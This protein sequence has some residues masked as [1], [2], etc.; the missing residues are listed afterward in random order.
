MAGPLC[1]PPFFFK[2]MTDLMKCAVVLLV[3]TMSTPVLGQEAPSAEGESI[4]TITTDDSSYKEIIHRQ[5]NLLEKIL[6]IQERTLLLLE[7]SGDTQTQTESE[8]LLKEVAGVK[9]EIKQTGEEIKEVSKGKEKRKKGFTVKILT[10]DEED[11]LS[12]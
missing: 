7:K 10:R 5:L 8:E 4:E 9:K 1:G 12:P 2:F 11:V 6:R 3:L